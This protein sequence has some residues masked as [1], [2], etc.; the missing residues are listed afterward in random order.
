[1]LSLAPE[2][3]SVF[4]DSGN[5]G[6]DGVLFL[7]LCCGLRSGH[8]GKVA[9]CCGLRSGHICR[10]QCASLPRFGRVSLENAKVGYFMR[11]TT[12][13]ENKCA[14]VCRFVKRC[15]SGAGHS[16][17]G[18]GR[19]AVPCTTASFLV[20][21]SGKSLPAVGGTGGSAKKQQHLLPGCPEGGPPALPGKKSLRR[22]GALRA[23]EAT[24]APTLGWRSR[25]EGQ[26]TN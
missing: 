9:P 7:E 1:M 3:G 22:K 6:Q 8:F 18:R 13:L 24:N 20:G 26:R 5:A 17:L 14:T 21:R 11:T 10:G 12:N 16:A 15:C 2:H 4:W 23:L 25:A 19:R